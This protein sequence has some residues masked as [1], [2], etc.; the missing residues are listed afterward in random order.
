MLA[1]EENTGSNRS[2]ALADN[3]HRRTTEEVDRSR[4]QLV[5]ADSK[6]GWSAGGVVYNS[7]G[8]GTSELHTV[9]DAC[10][11]NKRAQ[12]C[13]SARLRISALWT[14]ATLSLHQRGIAGYGAPHG[15]T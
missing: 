9:G 4:Q 5:G 3:N 8:S 15:D 13:E 11:D 6:E 14:T 12:A 10:S 2:T 7:R 1:G